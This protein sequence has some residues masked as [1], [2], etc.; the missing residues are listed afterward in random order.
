MQNVMTMDI[1]IEEASKAFRVNGVTIAKRHLAKTFPKGDDMSKRLARFLVIVPFLATAYQVSPESSPSIRYT[2]WKAKRVYE[3]LGIDED[4]TVP[5]MLT[6][7][8]LAQQDIDAIGSQIRE[9]GFY[10]GGEPIPFAQRERR[11]NVIPFPG[12]HTLH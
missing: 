11:D 1:R 12:K 9:A 10:E 4:T 7:M 6:F 5:F 2:A 3:A 8:K